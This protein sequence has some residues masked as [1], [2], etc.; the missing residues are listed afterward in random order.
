MRPLVSLFRRRHSKPTRRRSLPLQA[1]ALE[2]RALLAT[3]TVSNLLSAGAGSLRAAVRNANANPGADEI[4]F[5]VAGTIPLATALPAITDTVS[6]DGS[7]APDFVGSPRITVNF[8]GQ[9]G[10]RFAPGSDGSSLLNV[11]VIRAAGAGVTLDASG[12]TLAGNSIGVL[13]N[14]TTAAPNTGSGVLV[15]AR[16]SGNR[17]GLA[18]AIDYDVTTSVAAAGGSTLPVAG[19]QGLTTA[20]SPGQYF[21][22]G[23]TTITK[24]NDPSETET[25]GLLYQGPLSAEGG[26]GYVMTMPDLQGLTIDGTTAYSADNLGNGQLR[27]VGTYSVSGAPNELGFLF[28]G[29]VA[30]V[31]TAAN[32]EP[33]LRPHPSATWNI[34]HSTSGGLVVGNYDSSTSGGVPAGGGLAYVYD[35]VNRTYLVPSMVYPGSASNTAYG[36]WWNGGTS[37]TICGGFANSPINNLLNPRQPLSQAL[38]VDFDSASKQFSNWKSF[39]YTSPSSGASGITHF[40]GVSGVEPGTYTLAAVAATEAGTVA[41]FVNVRRNVDGSF[42]EMQWTD[43]EPP[44]VGGSAFADSVYGNAVV[45]IDPSNTGVN[46]YQAT[47]TPGGNLISGNGG[48]GVRIQGDDNVVA[49]NL[50]GTTITGAAALANGGDGVRLEAGATGNRVGHVDPVTTIA[51]AS[52]ADVTLPVQ[53]WTGIR[54]LDN[55]DYLITGSTASGSVTSGLLYIGSLDGG[56]GEAYAINYPGGSGTTTSVYGPDD[57]GGGEVLLVGTYVLPTGSTRY[58]FAFRGN[59]ATM[60]TDVLD[61]NNY[62]TIWNGSPFNYLHSAMGGLAV[63]NFITSDTPNEQGRAYIYD[64]E[65]EEFTDIVFPGSVSNTAYG[66]WDNGNGSYTIA[67]GFSQVPVNNADDRL[68]PIGLASLIDYDRASGTFSN[69]RS[70]SYQ[71]PDQ[72]TVGTHFMGISSVEKGVYTLSGTG[73]VSGT[74]ESSGLATVVRQTDGSFGDMA[75]VDLAPPESV[76][77]VSG[78]PSANSVYGNAVVGIVLGESGTASYQAQVNVGFQPS[79]LISG[80]RGQGVAIAGG[81]D[82]VVAMNLIGTDF[83]GQAAVPNQAN[84]I[85]VTNGAAGNLIGGFAT[86]GNDPTG[87]VFVRPPQGNLISGNRA[88]GMLVTG[89]ATGNTL[90]GNFV[91]TTGSG[92]AALGNAADGVAIV[93]ASGNSLLGTTFRQDPF[94]FYN[95]LSGNGG[96]GLRI[97]NSNDTTVQAN[98]TGVGADNATV[99]ANGGSGILVNGTSA[100]TIVGGPIPLGNV[101]SGNNRYG[102]E[103]AGKASGFVAFN[104]FVG[105]VAFGNAA[106]NRLDGIHITS[107][108][109]NNVIRTCLVA[110]NF[111]NGIVLAGNAT[112]VTVEDT[113]AGTNSAIS[114]AIPNYGSGVL[115]TGNAQGNAIG[116]FQVSI[117]TKVHLSG[118]LRY[119]L[120]IT[121]KARNNRIFNSVIGAAFEAPNP[122]PNGLG[123]ILVGPGT[124]GTII[125]GTQPFMANR[126]LT[127]SGAGITISGSSGNVVLGNEIRGNLLDGITLVNAS[128]TTVGA[129]G[130]G[131]VIV[132]N[133]LNGIA[134]ARASRGTVIVANSIVDSGGNGIVL[135]AA[136]DLLVG[137]TAAGAGNAIV[138][139]AGYGLLAV[140]GCSRTRVIRNR[141]ARNTLG[142]VDLSSSS[143]I[144]Y[145]P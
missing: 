28:N 51:Y 92:N 25:A 145:A 134:V 12:V 30:D 39:T 45:G 52:A 19:W 69:W 99:V 26:A 59:L 11:A 101:N 130:V 2:S 95:V 100:R 112:G 115:I 89:G 48:A 119:G 77:G 46:T 103:V 21:I 38:L 56:D 131:N 63:G 104:S 58:G 136:T 53:T 132:S 142:D 97:T 120:E 41:G 117:Q 49:S 42:G 88:N 22:T 84:G 108:G 1:E 57:L 66:I 138:T 73:F 82:N 81:S 102:I 35:A 36:I 129:V 93:N 64:F 72:A 24:P 141:I 114:E 90:S 14:G 16:G 122:I 18:T 55:G 29:T 65:S 70:Y 60:A 133:G 124:T 54:G 40:E 13:P 127:N 118:N 75:W 143:G 107:T 135:N 61:P 94:V 15:T 113:A 137:G 6:I 17:I 125:G 111:G 76:T 123:G 144:T 85:L 67:G 106:P 43:L 126:V 86:A 79:N 128:A 34:P 50:I 32:Y 87:D 83:A 91:G 80:N 7:T 96:N 116:G 139:S 4:A 33:I 98:F 71:S 20:G 8:R 110:G 37:Y 62:E 31:G 27:I 68:R 5:A 44:V 74:I 10:L 9:S 105:L 3:F 109:G 23:T 78:L 121:G 47:I 140:G